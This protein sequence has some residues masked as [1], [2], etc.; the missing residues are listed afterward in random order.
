MMNYCNGV[1]GFINYTLFNPR[2]INKCGIRCS[3]KKC[4]NKKFL[5]TDVVTIH[6]L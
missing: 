4:K 3:Y 5:D 2:N 6:L 1:W